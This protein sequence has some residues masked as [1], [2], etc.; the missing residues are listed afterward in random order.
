VEVE[1]GLV[2]GHMGRRALGLIQE[3]RD[4]RKS[5]LTTDWALAREKKSLHTIKPLE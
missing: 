3:W 2:T 5:E 1:S 4:L